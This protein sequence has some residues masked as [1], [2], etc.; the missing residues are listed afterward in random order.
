MLVT[1]TIPHLWTDLGYDFNPGQI[2]YPESQV[3]EKHGKARP[4]PWKAEWRHEV[5][6]LLQIENV[7]SPNATRRWIDFDVHPGP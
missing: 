3:L 4:F 7:F 1:G 6:G 2:F 5:E